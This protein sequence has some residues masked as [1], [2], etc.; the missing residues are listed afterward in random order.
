MRVGFAEADGFLRKPGEIVN[1][2]SVFFTLTGDSNRTD[3][4]LTNRNGN[5]DVGQ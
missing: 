3:R 2:K 5:A 4:F 1:S